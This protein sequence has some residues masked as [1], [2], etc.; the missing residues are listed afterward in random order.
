MCDEAA[1]YKQGDAFKFL[2]ENLFP[3]S[4]L[5]YS[6]LAKWG[7]VELLQWLL[8]RHNSGKV[9]YIERDF[10]PLSMVSESASKEG[11]LD[12]L[13]WLEDNDFEFDEYVGH[14]A[15]IN[16]HLE[17]V[18]WL[19]SK[20]FDLNKIDSTEAVRSGNLQLV[21]WLFEKKCI[22]CTNSLDVAAQHNYLE[23]LK[24]L[25]SKGF[26]L[27]DSVF[28]LT[29]SVEI[30]DYLVSISCPSSNISSTYIRR[31]DLE[32][33]K[34][35]WKR[36]LKQRK[37]FFSNAS[38]QIAISFG[39]FEIAEWLTKKKFPL[40]SEYVHDA[41]KSGSVKTAD[42]MRKKGYCYDEACFSQAASIIIYQYFNTY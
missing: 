2:A 10:Y 30:L 7:N 1:Q 3:I 25:V 11:H 38:V 35:L 40:R 33:V 28:R 18:K 24:L 5:T 16:G 39:N 15:I 17:V 37:R 41:I 9:N 29:T 36:K 12:T 14:A 19:F 23:I 6:M 21:E 31:G 20:G 27:Q 4:I 22:F 42:W 32:C 8:E 13:K 26:I 34:L